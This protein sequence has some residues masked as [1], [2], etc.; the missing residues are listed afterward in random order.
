MSS[1]PPNALALARRQHQV[2]S[3]EQLTQSGVTTRNRK[4]LL[5]NSTLV[6]VHRGVYRFTTAPDTLESQCVAA[7]LAVP[8]F[9][10]SGPTAGRLRRFRGMPLGPIHGITRGGAVHL[11]GVVVHRTNALDWERDVDLR[12]DGIRLLRL[13]RHVFDLA[14]F[15]DDDGFESVV[16]QILDRRLT[17]IPAIFAA[18]RRLRKMGRDGS[19]RFG[20]VLAR[21]PA[22]AKPKDSDQEV[23]VLR[24][25][26][27]RGIELVPQF[28]VVLPDGSPAYLDGADPARK[29]G[30]EV[31]HVTWHG[32]RIKSQYDKWRDRQLSRIGWRV[33]RVTDEDVDRRFHATIQEL[34][35]IHVSC[36]VA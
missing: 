22:W 3:I 36:R 9:M 18:G 29:F 12:P 17:T 2:I 25:L 7:C 1:P 11:D 20:R 30:V 4:T 24:E 13:P 14:R 23:K 16:E 8:G 21:R 32:G 35:D 34:V 31:D 28:L 33:P 10:I 5:H 15:L 6:E 26:R 27:R 19:A